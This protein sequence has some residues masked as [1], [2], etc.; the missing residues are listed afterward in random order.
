MYKHG[1]GDEVNELIYAC[2]VNSDLFKKL[3]E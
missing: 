2:L 3:N 1:K